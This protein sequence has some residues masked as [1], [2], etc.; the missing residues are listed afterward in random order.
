MAKDLVVQYTLYVNP[1][2][3]VV[4]VTS[5]VHSVWSCA[6]DEIANAGN[7]EQSPKRIHIVSPRSQRERVLDQLPKKGQ[8][9]SGVGAQFVHYMKNHI[10]QLYGLP[11]NPTVIAR[12][13]E[14]LLENDRFRCP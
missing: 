6:Q 14:Y 7:I 8:K 13:V 1:L 12:G 5:E 10:W 11:D 3:N 4:A 2:L 9:D